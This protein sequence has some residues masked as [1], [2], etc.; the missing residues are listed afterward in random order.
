MAQMRIVPE[1]D[2]WFARHKKRFEAS[3]RRRAFE[4]YRRRD[5]QAR[6][7][8]CDWEA[9]KQQLELLPLAGV[10][11]TDREVRVSACIELESC[12]CD[13]L[14]TLRVMPRR[15]VAE[16][17]SRFSVLELPSPIRTDQVRVTLEGDR[18]NVIAPRLDEPRNTA[19]PGPAPAQVGAKP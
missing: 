8:P 3:V 14:I 6:T 12:G 15:I 16:S 9:A 7:A 1:S 18:L 4:I 10:D 2:E 17:G 13:S 11:E 19:R 5:R